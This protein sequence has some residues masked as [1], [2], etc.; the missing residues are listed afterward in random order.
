MNSFQQTTAFIKT[1]ASKLGF[2][3]CGIARAQKLD[4]DAYRLEE[5]LNKGMHG[6]M[7]YM[8]NYFEMR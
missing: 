1:S 6:T 7:Q 3:Y 2:D 8:E 5:W 4:A